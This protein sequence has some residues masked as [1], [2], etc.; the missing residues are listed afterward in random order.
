MINGRPSFAVDINPV[1]VLITKAKSTPVNPVHVEREF[2]SFQM[3]LDVYNGDLPVS[4]PEYERIYYW[5]MP[6]DKRKL[7]FIL[8]EISKINEQKPEE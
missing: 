4:A 5:F 7:A 6:D 2:I 8:A 3:K 1:A